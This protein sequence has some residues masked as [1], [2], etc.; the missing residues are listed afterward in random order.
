MRLKQR[1]KQNTALFKPETDKRYSAN[2]V[3]T[4]DNDRADCIIIVDADELPEKIE[5]AEAQI[6]KRIRIRKKVQRVLKNEKFSG[7]YPENCDPKD[8]LFGP[9][10]IPG[11][12]FSERSRKVGSG[13]GKGVIVEEGLAE[14]RIQ[15][16]GID[17]IQFVRG[18]IARVCGELRDRGLRIMAAGLDMDFLRRPFSMKPSGNIGSLLAI[19][20]RVDKMKA[21]CQCCG[22]EASFSW[23]LTKA[24][25]VIQPGGAK[26]Y[27]AVCNSCYM[28]L[29]KDQQKK[30]KKIQ[31]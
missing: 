9:M 4:H 10:A 28:E 19:A 30:Y 26:E 3:V 2:E 8:P 5:E 24:T 18:D 16:I 15:V 22:D 23:R 6:Q 27:A 20:D 7:A 21:V 25:G 12:Y 11:V 14:N 31:G 17:E 1:A 29:D 13:K